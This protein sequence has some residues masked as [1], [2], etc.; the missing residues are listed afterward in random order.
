MWWH[1]SLTKWSYLDQLWAENMNFFWNILES[2]N[3]VCHQCI[4]GDRWYVNHLYPL[5]WPRSISKWSDCEKL[6]VIK[7]GW[8]FE[9]IRMDYQGNIFNFDLIFY[10]SK[11]HTKWFWIQWTVFYCSTT[12]TRTKNYDTIC[13][14][15][16]F[17]LK[18]KLMT[19]QLVFDIIFMK[20]KQ[21]IRLLKI[22]YA[23]TYLRL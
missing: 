18:L 17:T 14:H 13:N 7:M 10:W 23:L 3:A 22:V 2:I 9:S 19:I 5:K 1:R 12:N 20:L 8:N 6:F 11:C 15:Y 16:H 4:V 21:I